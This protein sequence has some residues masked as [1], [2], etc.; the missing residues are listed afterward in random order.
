[1][2]KLETKPETKWD[3]LIASTDFR[4]LFRYE[5][6]GTVR[7]YNLRVVPEGA[8]LWVSA[9][10]VGEVAGSKMKMLFRNPDEAALVL[11]DIE[12]TLQGGGW[13]QV[14]A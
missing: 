7:I 6:D 3:E 11:Q 10:N 2:A 1:M 12:R 13:R 4:E 9:A 14:S 5:K 8:E